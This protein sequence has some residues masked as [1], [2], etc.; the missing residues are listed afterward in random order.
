MAIVAE[1]ERHHYRYGANPG[2]RE[3]PLLNNFRTETVG[4]FNAAAKSLSRSWEPTTR[5]QRVHF[6]TAAF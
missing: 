6:S 3:F 2:V 1:F 5:N 4:R